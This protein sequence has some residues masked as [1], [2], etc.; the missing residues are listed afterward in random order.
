VDLKRANEFGQIFDKEKKD[1]IQP[2]QKVKDFEEASTAKRR[3]VKA[4]KDN[5]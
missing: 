4:L 1:E 2:E 5:E 3:K